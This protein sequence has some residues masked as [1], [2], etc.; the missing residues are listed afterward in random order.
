MYNQLKMYPTNDDRSKYA[1]M[2]MEMFALIK[3]QIQA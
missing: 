3:L 2:A 1:L